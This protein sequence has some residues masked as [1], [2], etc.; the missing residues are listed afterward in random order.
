M[1][2]DTDAIHE[3]TVS[4]ENGH[5]ILSY[6]DINTCRINDNLSNPPL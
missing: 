5:F 4:N 6:I 1:K 2:Q 3:I